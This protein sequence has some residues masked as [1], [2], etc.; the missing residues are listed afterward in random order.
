MT[1]EENVKNYI[2]CCQPCDGLETAK[3]ADWKNL[4][5]SKWKE[6]DKYCNV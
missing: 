5:V 2:L 6:L 3:V 4:K 1:G